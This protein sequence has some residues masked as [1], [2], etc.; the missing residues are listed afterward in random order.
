MEEILAE[1]IAEGWVNEERFARAACRGK[2]RMKGWGKRKIRAWLRERDISDYCI[3]KGMEEIDEEEYSQR[4]QELMLRKW[5]QLS[6]ESR[7]QH[8]K[9]KTY[10]YLVQKG[11]EPQQVLKELRTICPS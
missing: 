1:A 6:G 3:E 9:A 7:I 5:D 2:F 10:D 8:R 11:Y 4:M